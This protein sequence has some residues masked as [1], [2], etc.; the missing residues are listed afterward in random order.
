MSPIATALGTPP[1]PGLKVDDLVT[2]E[3]IDPSIKMP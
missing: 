2:N 3:F 1:A